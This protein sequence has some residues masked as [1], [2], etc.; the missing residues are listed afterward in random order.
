MKKT[1]RR[2]Q[3]F[4]ALAITALGGACNA[5]NQPDT[6]EI[7]GWVDD[8]A[9]YR[10]V[11]DELASREKLNPEQALERA[12]DLARL[13]LAYRQSSQAQDPSPQRASFLRKRKAV[14]IWLNEVFEPK[15]GKDSVPKKMIEQAQEHN[16]RRADHF[17]PRLHAICQLVVRPIQE[18]DAR[19]DPQFE[20][21]ARRAISA[22]EQALKAAQPELATQKQC[23]HFQ[24][25]AGR[26]AKDSD[27]SLKFK[28]EVLLIDLSKP[29]WDKD[30]VRVV[31]SQPHAGLIP[32]FMT[33]FGLHLVYLTRVYKAHL[34]PEPDG[35]LSERTRSLRAEE[36]RGILLDKWRAQA[37]QEELQRMRDG[38]SVR[39]LKPTS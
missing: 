21:Q 33:R 37:L 38:Q 14:R 25:L 1:S 35:S 9:I 16:K 36:L 24:A 30:F 12:A 5:P 2:S 22:F 3:L 8:E 19:Q 27:P 13:A 15:H 4:W 20:P 6:T 17:R 18:G 31:Q 26:L 23:A 39:W 10:S 29:T 11:V 32:A 28:V 34:A 7:V